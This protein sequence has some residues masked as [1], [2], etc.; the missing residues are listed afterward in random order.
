MTLS[1][2]PGSSHDASSPSPGQHLGMVSHQGRFWDVYLEVEDDPRRP[3]TSR[4]RLCFSPS[5]LNE[6]EEPVRTATIIIEPSYEE[7]VRKARGFEDHQLVGLLRS[8]QPD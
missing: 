6:G 4:G 8:A 7:A 2:G 1:R 3:G 5:D